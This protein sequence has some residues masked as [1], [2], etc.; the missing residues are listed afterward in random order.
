MT[1]IWVPNRNMKIYFRNGDVIE[2]HVDNID[3]IESGEMEFR[4]K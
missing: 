4:D 3:R 1:T 2:Y